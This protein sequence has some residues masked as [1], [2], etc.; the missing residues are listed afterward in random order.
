MTPNA[1]ARSLGSWNVTVISASAAGASSAAKPPCR[2][3]AAISGPPVGARP[4]TQGGDREAEQTDDEGAPTSP[5][6]GDAT[7]EQQQAAEGQ[8]VGGDDPLHVGWGDAQI[9]LRGG[10]A[11][12]TIEASS[13]I[14]SWAMAMTARARKRFG[15][16]NGMSRS[17][18]VVSPGGG[19]RRARRCLRGIY[20]GH[21]CSW[22]LGDAARRTSCVREIVVRSTNH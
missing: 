11:R 8:G 19:R 3:R 7:A 9:G 12:F 15:S 18:G 6:V 14:I 21:S 1:L 22:G 17:G 2:A 4:P 13:T 5:V 10:I 16:V 20:E